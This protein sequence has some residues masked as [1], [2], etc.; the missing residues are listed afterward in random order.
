MIPITL[1]RFIFVPNPRESLPD[2]PIGVRSNF[3]FKMKVSR[4]KIMLIDENVYLMI[5]LVKSQFFNKGV[6]G[7]GYFSIEVPLQENFSTEL[8]FFGRKA[9]QKSSF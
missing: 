2:F 9:Y 7:G 6:W 1:V 8:P 3:H 4:L 5:Q